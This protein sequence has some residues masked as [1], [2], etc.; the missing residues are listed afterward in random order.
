MIVVFYLVLGMYLSWIA[1]LTFALPQP[2]QNHPIKSSEART[3]FSVVIPMRNESEHLPGLLKSISELSYPNHLFEVIVVDDDS[4]DN[5][6][7]TVRNFQARH[8]TIKT[9]LLSNLLLKGEKV[10]PKPNLSPKKKAIHKAISLASYDYIITTD[11][12][13]FL[14][15]HWLKCYDVKLQ[16]GKADLIA[17]GVVVAPGHSL[18]SQYQHLDMLGLQLFGYGSFARE[19]YVICNGANLCYKKSTYLE[20]NVHEGKESIA[21]GD[22]VFTLEKFRLFNSKIEFL[23]DSRAVVWTQPVAS[24]QSLWHQRVRWAKKS[25]AMKSLY[26][27]SCGLL[28]AFMQL[29]LILGLFFAFFDTVFLTFL[30]NA[31][32]LKFLVDAWSL[33]KIAKLQNLGFCWTDFFKV[34]LVYPFLTSFFAFSSLFGKFEWKG[35]KYTK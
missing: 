11:A 8:P 15:K 5:S 7:A 20:A 27:K 29:S 3:S 22:D 21:S 28:V 4:Q 14:P 31:F 12:D 26:L 23:Y 35:R 16:D 17:A 24:F 19:Q 13:V 34:S 25:A 30:I 32:V 1:W 10:G 6:W 9:F 18:L 33:S 2:T